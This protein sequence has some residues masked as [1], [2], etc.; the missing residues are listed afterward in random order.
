MHG[1]EPDE[2]AAFHLTGALGALRRSQSLLLVDWEQ[3]CRGD[4]AFLAAFRRWEEL[5]TAVRLHLLR[6]ENRLL[7]LVVAGHQRRDFR[8][9]RPE[10]ERLATH[11]AERFTEWFRAVHIDPTYRHLDSVLDPQA[12]PI[13]AD[14]ITDFATVAEVAEAAMPALAELDR[15]LDERELEDLAFSCV[16]APWRNRGLPAMRQIER[17]L[18]EMVVEHGD[19]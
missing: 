5:L 4:Q 11:W 12:D 8:G 17:W 13:S 19:W 18:D 14:I 16:I 6:T 15:S 3:T 10:R 2:R 7:H 9:E 1:P